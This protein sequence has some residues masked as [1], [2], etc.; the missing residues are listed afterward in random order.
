[1]QTNSVRNLS[2]YQSINQFSNTE[3][4]QTKIKRYAQKFCEKSMS[5]PWVR[6]S[7]PSA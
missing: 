1:M 5:R 3:I 2:R 7:S 4:I 6:L